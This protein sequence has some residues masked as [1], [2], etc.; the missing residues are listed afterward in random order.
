MRQLSKRNVQQNSRKCM[1]M[2][3]A[4]YE[5]SFGMVITNLNVINVFTDEFEKV[6][7][8]GEYLHSLR[9]IPITIYRC[10]NHLQLYDGAEFDD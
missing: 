5:F 2:T 7:A 4:L 9:S 8:E 6:K 10:D 1:I 3:D